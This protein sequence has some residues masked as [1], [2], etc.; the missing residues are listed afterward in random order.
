MPSAHTINP[1]DTLTPDR[2]VRAVE[3]GVGT[4]VLTQGNETSVVEAV[5]TFDAGGA[6]NLSIY[7][8]K[9]ARVTLVFA[10]EPAT[11]TVQ[12][13]PATAGTTTSPKTT[14]SPSTKKKKTARKKK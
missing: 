3:V 12:P 6:A 13:R 9:G 11:A 1:H 14:G 5:D 8:A 2:S 4:V 7:S 10:D